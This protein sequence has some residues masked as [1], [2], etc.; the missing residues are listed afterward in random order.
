MT[1]EELVTF[2]ESDDEE[3]TKIDS[4]KKEAPG[5][6]HLSRAAEA[7]VEIIQEMNH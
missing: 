3:P 4:W 6:R 7:R 1:D 5:G 2:I